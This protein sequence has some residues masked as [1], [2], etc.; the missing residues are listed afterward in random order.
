[1][2]MEKSIMK[3]ESE[4]DS[5]FGKPPSERSFEELLNLGVIN[6]DKPSGPTS[7]Q[8]VSWVKKV[9]DVNKTGHGGTLDPR[10]TGVLPVALNKSVKGLQTLLVGKKEYVGIMHLHHKAKDERFQEVCKEFV[11]EIYQLPPVRAAVKRELRK[12]WIYYLDI[13]EFDGKYA[14]FKVGCQA[15]TYIRT[16]VRDIGEV[17]GVGAHMQELRRTKSCNF[18]EE[19]SHTLHDLKDALVFWNDEGDETIKNII[20]PMERMFEHIPKILIKDSSVDAICHGANLAMPGIAKLDAGIQRGNMIAI[21]SLKGEGVAV[22]I[23][24]LSTEQM[25]S[26]NDGIAAKTRSVLMETGTY[27][28]LW[29]KKS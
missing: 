1:M 7:H 22:A 29:S 28:M 19:N 10:V 4:T 27:P 6:L 5:R 13:M 15:G 16:L 21:L 18:N 3:I 2:M 24:T 17:L 14:L 9:L 11:G 8:V 23:A 12:R 20:L 25:I 26:K